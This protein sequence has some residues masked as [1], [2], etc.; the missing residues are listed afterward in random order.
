MIAYSTPWFTIRKGEDFWLLTKAEQ[1]AVLAHERGHIYHWHAWKRIWWIIT[2]RALR[3]HEDFLKMCEAQ[4]FEADRY[5]ADHG[6]A[7]GLMTVLL[8]NP[9]GV[10]SP[11]Y[12]SPAER[13]GELYE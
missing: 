4:E 2:L 6:H 12:P 13:I 3:R 7:V 9:S 10:K 5:A 11:G 8:R 1:Q